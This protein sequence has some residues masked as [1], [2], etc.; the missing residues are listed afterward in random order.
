[1]YDLRF[2]MREWGFLDARV[3]VDLVELNY[4]AVYH[5]DPVYTVMIEK[6]A[7]PETATETELE[8]V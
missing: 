4:Y 6:P 2:G 5:N 1:M 7:E 3:T 8:D